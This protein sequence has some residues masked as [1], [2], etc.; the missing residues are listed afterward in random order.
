MCVSNCSA[1]LTACAQRLTSPLTSACFQCRRRAGTWAP[2]ASTPLRRL[3]LPPASAARQHP[4]PPPPRPPLRPQ[5]WHQTQASPRARPWPQ[6]VPPPCPTHQSRKRRPRRAPLLPPPQPGR[7]ALPTAARPSHPAARR[8]TA[9]RHGILSVRV[10]ERTQRPRRLRTSRFAVPTK[11]V[12]LGGSGADS[13]AT[14]RHNVAAVH[15]RWQ[16]AVTRA[17]THAR[18]GRRTL[19]RLGR[20]ARHAHRR[21]C[22]CRSRRLLRLWLHI[23]QRRRKVN[24]A[25]RLHVAAGGRDGSQRR[26]VTRAS[27]ATTTRASMMVTARCGFVSKMSM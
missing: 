24:L 4:H 27:H 12:N 10:H 11:G 19:S 18:C 16:R 25:V 17:V 20:C 9:A 23:I 22:R 3:L 6:A 21:R 8:H 2:Q 14:A 26:A 7:G 13:A 1:V 5:A 15:Q